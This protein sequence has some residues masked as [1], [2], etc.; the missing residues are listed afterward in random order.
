MTDV[1]GKGIIWERTTVSDGR[2]RGSGIGDRKHSGDQMTPW[3][4][5]AG[6]VWWDGDGGCLVGRMIPCEGAA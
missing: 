4:D 6:L 2:R 5:E 1:T 3:R